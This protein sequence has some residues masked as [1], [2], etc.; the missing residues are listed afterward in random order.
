MTRVDDIQPHAL[1]EL[2]KPVKAEFVSAE[3]VPATSNWPGVLPSGVRIR[4]AWDHYP[5]DAPVYATPEGE[6]DRALIEATF[7][8]SAEE[9]DRSYGI[10]IEPGD[11]DEAF[12]AI[13]NRRWV[14]EDL[15]L[16][17]EGHSRLL[18][19]HLVMDP[20]WL[21]VLPPAMR[22]EAESVLKHWRNG[23]ITLAEYTDT[24]LRSLEALRNAQR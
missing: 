21:R 9:G 4:V 22:A 20:A 15:D 2:T 7:Q 3:Q 10:R 1:L 5:G 6:R 17:I 19:R 12:T 16:S 11:L 8:R 14:P 18:V 24:T 23:S 13:E